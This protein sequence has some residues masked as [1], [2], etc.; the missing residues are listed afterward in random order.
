MT[1]FQATAL[2]FAKRLFGGSSVVLAVVYTIGHIFIAILCVTIIT[3]APLELAA[4]D[5]LVE[6]IINGFWF[7]LLHSTWKRFQN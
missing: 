3:G 2:S 5:A 4:I 1:E 6:P 7:Y